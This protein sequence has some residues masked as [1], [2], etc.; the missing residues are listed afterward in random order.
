MVGLSS[1]VTG[2]EPSTCRGVTGTEYLGA[3]IFR[4]FCQSD[5]GSAPRKVTVTNTSHGNAVSGNRVGRGK[6]VTG[7]ESGTCKRVTGVEYISA[8]QSQAYCGEFLAKSPR[9]VTRT[10]TR[11]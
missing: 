4:D 5:P 9:K 6:N 1:A 2:D 3:D 10:E 8:D 11:K 7:N